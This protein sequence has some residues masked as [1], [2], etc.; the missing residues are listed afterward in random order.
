MGN[1]IDLLTPV[2][3]P[4]AQ[5]YGFSENPFDV[6]KAQTEMQ[7]YEKLDPTKTLAEQLVLALNDFTRYVGTTYIKHM[8]LMKLHNL[9][10]RSLEYPESLVNP[11]ASLLIMNKHKEIIFEEKQKIK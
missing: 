7:E 9:V 6:E 11:G 4:T 5:K 1:E 2:G 10:A 3:S 8:K